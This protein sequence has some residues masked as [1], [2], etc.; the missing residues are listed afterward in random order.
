MS[1]YVNRLLN[2]KKIKIVGFDMDYTLVAYHINAFESLVH[3]LAKKRLVERFH[4]PEAVCDL[5][6]DGKMAIVGLVIDKR[7]GYLLQLNRFAK[8]KIAFYGTQQIDFRLLEEIY[9]ERVVDLRDPEFQSLDTAF[10]ISQGVLYIQL[11]QLKKEGYDIPDFQTIDRDITLC[12]DSLHKDNS[13]KNIL[14]KNFHKYVIRDPQTAQM[15][16][17][18]KAYGKKLIIIT[19]SD[20]EYTRNLLDYALNPYWS[21]YKTWRDVF[22]LVVTFAEKP[23]FFASRNRFLR[24]NPQTGAMSNHEGPVSSGIWQGGC[25]SDIQDGFGVPGNEFLYLGD[26]IYGDIVS[27]KKQCDWH[28][29][30]VLGGL[31]EEI[32]TIHKTSRLQAEINRLMQRKSVLEKQAN[33]VEMCR[34]AGKSTKGFKD[35]SQEQNHLNAKISELVE[36]LKTNFNPWWGE[37]LRSGSEESRY[38]DQVINYACIYMTKVADLGEYSPNTYFRPHRRLMAHER[39]AATD[40]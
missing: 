2:F 11:V 29:G 34:K 8:V 36:E 19:N 16:E 32:D 26:H 39:A 21:K 4:Y 22:D 31:Q 40:D 25:F 27:I 30:L 24:I 38:A 28:T 7:N 14:K 18:L 3:S 23:R 17:Q 6:F 9:R 20:Y 5:V 37:I 35:H 12:I 15:L 33:D 10:A 1:L 13:L